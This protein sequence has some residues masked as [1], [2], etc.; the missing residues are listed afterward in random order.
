MKAVG[1]KLSGDIYW[2]LAKNQSLLGPIKALWGMSIVAPHVYG[3]GIT[4]TDHSHYIPLPG[5]SCMINSKTLLLTYQEDN[6]DF[7]DMHAIAEGLQQYLNALRVVCGQAGLSRRV[8]C[9]TSPQDQA[10]QDHSE[11][12]PL[13]KRFEMVSLRKHIFDSAANEETLLK[14]S[15]AILT[16]SIPIHGELINDSAEEL[17]LS[18][19]RACLI[20]A[21]MAVESC[22]DTILDREYDRIT[23]EEESSPKHRFVTITVN[24]KESTRKDPVYGA[25]REGAGEGGSHFLSLLHECPL[26]LLGKSLEL[27]KPSVYQKAHSLYRTRNALAHTGTT[28]ETK[29]GLLPVTREG[30]IIAIETANAVLEWFGERGT[31]IPNDDYVEIRH[32]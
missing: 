12:R 20:F 25:L 8:V 2:R 4:K 18:N 15:D 9:V 1:I 3:E 6:H 7:P 26:Y 19:Y 32:D 27:D 10:I 30:A 21:A 11:V 24:K 22:A 23:K 13:S 28:T 29:D 5:G 31:C 17:I 14:A 16:E